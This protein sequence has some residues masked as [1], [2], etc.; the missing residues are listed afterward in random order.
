[1]MALGS[2]IKEIKVT[3]TPTQTTY[4]IG[5]VFNP[6]G[7][8][9]EAILTNGKKM[10]IS[11]YVQYSNDKMTGKET[12]V[13]IYYENQ[14]YNDE[15]QLD[16]LYATV[17]IQVNDKE[18]S[19]INNAAKTAI[20]KTKPVLTAKAGTKSVSLSWKKSSNASG[21]QV[22]RSTKKS[23]G[24]KSIKTVTKGTTVTYK[25]TGLTKGKTYYYKVRAYKVINGTKYY[26]NWSTVKSAK[27]K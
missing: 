14:M 2:K 16:M 5:D 25:N 19:A 13:T 18:V 7:M 15:E 27:V 17:D 21:Y 6:A 1:M 12:D 10:D 22:Y 4:D 23:S 9:V 3:K 8:K 26:G 11:Q 24:F 20:A